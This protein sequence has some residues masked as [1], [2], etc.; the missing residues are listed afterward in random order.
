MDDNTKNRGR[1]IGWRLPLALAAAAL[2][3]SGCS[4]SDDSAASG[5]D[6]ATDLAFIDEQLVQDETTSTLIAAAPDVRL[7]EADSELVRFEA[8]WVCEVQRRTFQTPEGRDE[9][10]LENLGEAGISEADYLAFRERVNLERDLR[11]SILYSYQETC[12]P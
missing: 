2:A 8:H 9:A 12:R 6:A 10:L 11:D 3:F 7:S 1:S 4:G 5:D